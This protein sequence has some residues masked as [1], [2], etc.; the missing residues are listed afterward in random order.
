[1]IKIEKYFAGIIPLL[2]LGLVVSCDPVQRVQTD[3]S[4]TSDSTSSKVVEEPTVSEELSKSQVSP[5]EPIGAD[6]EIQHVDRSSGYYRSP[7]DFD[8]ELSGTFG[9]LRGNH[10]H[11]G[12]DIRTGGVEGKPIYAVADGYVSRVKVS[13]WG[14][15]K[16]LYIAHPNG[17]TSVYGHLKTYQGDV[18]DAV[19]KEHYRRKSYEMDWYVPKGQIPIK[20]GQVIALSGNTGGSA[21][22]HLHFEIRDAQGRTVNPLL[23]GL[24]AVD[25]IRPSI[26]S[27]RLYALD[28]DYYLQH[29]TFANRLIRDKEVIHV[30]PGRYG[31][32]AKWVD[33]FTHKFNKLGINYAELL[34]DGT[35]VFTQTIE[36][37]AFEEGR[38]I[39]KHIDFW[40]FSEHGYRY[41]KMFRDRGNTLDF[42]KGNGAIEIKEGQKIKVQIVVHD[43]SKQN[44]QISFTLVGDSAAKPLENSGSAAF[45]GVLCSANKGITLNAQNAQV[46]VPAFA[47]YNDVI[48]RLEETPGTGTAVSPMIHIR[49]NH[50]PLN[51]PITVKIKAPDLPGVV[52]MRYDKA[53]RSSSYEGGKKQGA[54]VVETTKA[55]GVFYLAQD[56]VKPT[57][58]PTA[59]RRHVRYRVADNMS[60]IHRFNGYIDGQW[61]LL[62]YEPKQSALFGVLPSTLSSGTHTIRVEVED[63]AGNMNYS[64][65]QIT[66]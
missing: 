4:G 37:F 59:L 25:S 19:V 8:I 6:E 5:E 29:G 64:E 47:T 21:A 14:Y 60:G 55:F 33:Y 15:G 46:I 28:H 1:M 26:T 34:I 27:G 16:A 54:Y 48:L 39:N 24:V 20:K 3:G 50:V 30:Q 32:G 17:T 44:D 7:I 58:R 9:E 18:L 62:E 53:S 11:A 65:R 61:F 66:L 2:W 23:K 35:P 56:T 22:P 13:P 49:H 43:L 36:K 45:E 12:L 38:L 51:S 42:Y 52:M 41:V 57:I 40:H 31:A 10:F 63:G